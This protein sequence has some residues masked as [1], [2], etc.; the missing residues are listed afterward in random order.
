MI[1]STGQL[2]VPVVDKDAYNR[3]KK[4]TDRP[5]SGTAAAAGAASGMGVSKPVPAE[6]TCPLCREMMTDAVLIPCC[7]R[8][9]C[10]DCIRNYLLENNFV[11][12]ETDCKQENV[13]PDNLIPNRM[14]RKVCLS[15]DVVYV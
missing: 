4:T 2:V 12:P 6:M 15:H 5:P 9:Y 3:L 7:G 1:T 10:D 11:C 8:S 13:S 14:L